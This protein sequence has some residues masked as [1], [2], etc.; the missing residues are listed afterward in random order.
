MVKY[1]NHCNDTNEYYIDDENNVMYNIPHYY[2]DNCNDEYDSDELYLKDGQC[3]C[4]YCLAE[5]HT[6]LKDVI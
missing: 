6:C 5:K 4:K 3:F 2:C 1:E